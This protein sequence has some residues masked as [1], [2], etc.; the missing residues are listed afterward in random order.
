MSAA[1][2]RAIFRHTCTSFPAPY[3]CFT[4]SLRPDFRGEFPILRSPHFWSYMLL[5]LRGPCSLPYGVLG[6][7][8]ECLKM[9]RTIN[10]GLSSSVW[11]IFTPQPF[12]SH[13][14]TA[15]VPGFNFLCF[16]RLWIFKRFWFISSFFFFFLSV[17][18][19]VVKPLLCWIQ[20]VRCELHKGGALV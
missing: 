19:I 5:Q 1:M 4:F 14:F 9:L 7:L 6:Q 15:C 18:V 8:F 13:I 11:I 16:I 10:F 12:F 2:N 17:A 20:P 3:M